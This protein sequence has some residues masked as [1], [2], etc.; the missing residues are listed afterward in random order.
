MSNHPDR[1]DPDIF[2]AGRIDLKIPFFLPETP[3]EQE[4]ILRKMGEKNRID[5]QVTDYAPVTG[6]MKGASGADLE[7]VVLLAAQIADEQGRSTVTEDDLAAAA[8]DYIPMRD[9]E[10]IAYMTLLAVYYCSS[11]RLLPERYRDLSGEELG[12]RL[13]GMAVRA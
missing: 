11:R 9:E 4:A 5:L 8:A 2:R 10:T 12:R 6:R 1:V 13:R 7:A 3:A